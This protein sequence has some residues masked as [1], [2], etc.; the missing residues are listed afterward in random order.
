M[1]SGSI[2]EHNLLVGEFSPVDSAGN[3]RHAR[4]GEIQ[5]CAAHELLLGDGDLVAFAGLIQAFDNKLAGRPHFEDRAQSKEREF[6]M[7][8]GGDR[9]R[10][11]RLAKHHGAAFAGELGGAH[12]LAAFARHLRARHR[13]RRL[14]FAR[15]RP[16]RFRR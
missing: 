4:L 10:L 15:G 8:D 9:L 6:R 11:R 3:E 1:A 14:R 7:R 5:E 2:F 12:H 16:L 13:R